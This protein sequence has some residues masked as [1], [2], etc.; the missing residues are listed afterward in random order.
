MTRT[1]R[2]LI[3]EE[4]ESGEVDVGGVVDI[5]CIDAEGPVE[6]RTKVPAGLGDAPR[7]MAVDLGA[8][9]GIVAEEAVVTGG[10][11][12]VGV[13][14]L[15]KAG[16]LVDPLGNGRSLAI[17]R[18]SAARGSD[19]ARVIDELPCKERGLILEGGDDELDVCLK[20]GM[21]CKSAR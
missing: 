16:E 6:G 11:E 8:L 5:L 15:D 19:A 9:V 3:R 17:S 20:K 12:M 21:S 14:R 13:D 1:V 2:F 7:G 10:Q 4:P 18:G